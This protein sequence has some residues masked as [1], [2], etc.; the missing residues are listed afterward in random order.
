MNRIQQ[1][2]E[3]AERD[4]TVRGLSHRDVAVEEAATAPYGAAER[5]E[6]SEEAQALDTFAAPVGSDARD[7]AVD[8]PDREAP[9]SGFDSGRSAARASI[10]AQPSPL[11]VAALAA[12]VA[13]RRTIPL[14]AQP[15]QPG[16]EQSGDAG[17]S[18]HQPRRHDGKTVTALNLAL[19]MAQEFQRRVL[20]VDSRSAAARGPRAARA[21]C[22]PRARRRPDRRCFAGRRAHRDSR[23][24]AHGARA[25]RTY[26]RSGRDARLGT[27]APPDGYAR[28]EFDRIVIDSAPTTVTDPV[29]VAARSRTASSSSCGKARRPSPRSRALCR[30]WERRSSWEWSSTPVRRRSCRTMRRL[31]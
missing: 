28:T 27:D 30:A 23:L 1:I 12:G 26:D 8:G 24:P 5:F 31:A 25:G 19:T 20:I 10:Y 9:D 14:A 17:D 6:P 21:P 11:L 22:W 16:P 29:A 7:F 18:D 4:E 15:H 13:R 2:L 3:K